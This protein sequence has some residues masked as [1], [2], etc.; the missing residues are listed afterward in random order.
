[1]SS[2]ATEIVSRLDLQPHPEGGHYRRLYPAATSGGGRP[3]VTAVQFLLGRAEVS[4]WHRV[5][6]DECW[7]WQ[8]GGTLELLTFDEAGGELTRQMLGR[9]AE[10]VEPMRIVP[11][12]VWQA[13][14]PLGDFTLVICTVSPGFVWEGFELMDVTDPRVTP[15]RNA[16][17]WFD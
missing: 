17:V 14:R 1:M 2:S 4:R 7:H 13:A 9:S 11:A 15:L 12:G 16:G 8:Q 3:S 5:D 6:G 10:G